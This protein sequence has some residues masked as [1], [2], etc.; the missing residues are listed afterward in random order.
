MKILVIGGGYVGLTTAVGFAYLGNDIIVVEKDEEKVSLLINNEFDSYETSL[1]SMLHFYTSEGKIDFIQNIEELEDEVLYVFLCVGTPTNN[2]G[3]T[4]Y[5]QIDSAVIEIAENLKG[6]KIIIEKSTVPVGTHKRISNLID[7]VTPLL[8]YDIVSNPEFLR[9]G[10]ATSDFIHPDRIIIGTNTEKAYN[11]MKDLYKNFDF[12][13][14]TDIKTAEFVKYV[15]N[16]YLGMRLSYINM[17]SELCEKLDINVNE[18][19]KLVGMD[20]RIGQE[21]FHAGIGYGGSCLSK[22]IKAFINTALN[23]GLTFNMLRE[24]QI[25]NKNRITHFLD[26]INKNISIGIGSKIAILGLS[27]KPGTDDIRDSPALKLVDNLYNYEC[28]IHF[29]DPCAMG[30]FKKLYQPTNKLKYFNSIFDTVKDCDLVIIATDWDEY[31]DLDFS[32][33]KKYMKGDIIADARNCLD[34]QTLSDLGFKYIG[35]GQ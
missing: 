22:D 16:G 30:N 35:L 25:I 20:H 17:I 21:Y 27:F 14:F 33:V 12:V 28:S 15:S 24:A 9:E 6:Y 3:I 10:S 18:V 7:T 4:D 11:H 23:H 1:S 5:S 31:K 13:Y 32:L 8:T 26:K 29:N 19:S 34:K 2:K